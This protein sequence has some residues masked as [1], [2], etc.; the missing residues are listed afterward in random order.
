MSA[1]KNSGSLA[2]LG[3]DI[4]LKSCS[5]SPM[6]YKEWEDGTFAKF[7][8]QDQD[9]LLTGRT[10][11]RFQPAR[12]CFG[13][14]VE[15]E[16][17]VRESGTSARK[18]HGLD[19][20]GE[21]GAEQGFSRPR[22]YTD[23]EPHTQ[24]YSYVAGEDG[25]L[26][27]SPM[28]GPEPAQVREKV[29]RERR[30][31]GIDAEFLD[32]EMLLA[33][34][35]EFYYARLSEF[36]KDFQNWE[37]AKKEHREEVSKGLATLTKSLSSTLQHQFNAVI[38]TRDIAAIWRLVKRA[39]GPKDGSDGL[40]DLQYRFVTCNIEPGEEAEAFITRLERLARGFAAY[41]PQWVKTG[42]HLRI[43]VR[44][45]LMADKDNWPIYN[46][47]IRE[48]DRYREDWPTLRKRLTDASATMV[49]DAKARKSARAKASERERPEKPRQV[50][51]GGC[52]EGIG[53]HA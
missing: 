19:L 48:A 13:W 40:T 36:K 28:K 18:P 7:R 9:D 51:Q 52:G 47:E 12:P 3:K 21:I 2:P 39:A 30:S 23:T 33:R 44:I 17:R 53:S 31:P 42:E 49:H 6:L 4:V 20:R 29:A 50:R 38:E 8:I 34:T 22:S 11:S 32:D 26:E 45:A 16:V 1:E 15:V 43:Q 46:T 24:P 10:P 35:E 25:D 37:R 41:G 5:L 14:E 27:A